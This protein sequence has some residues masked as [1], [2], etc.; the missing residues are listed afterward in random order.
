MPLTVPDPQ[1][2]PPT[3]RHLR[4]RARRSAV[5][6][7]LAASLLAGSGLTPAQA[8]PSAPAPLSVT[9]P[10]TTTS[11][12]STASTTL[13][14]EDQLARETLSPGDG[15]ASADGGTTGGTEAEEIV[16]VTSRAELVDAVAGDEPKIVRVTEDIHADE[17]DD[18]SLMTC[19]DYQRDGYSWE[20]YLEAFDPEQWDGAAEGP[21]EEAR[22]ASHR[23]QGEQIRL[24]PGSNT[25]LIGA[26]GATL[27]GF[28]V[29]LAEVDNVIVR[30]LR[31][32]DPYD[33]FPQW[34]GNEWDVEWDNVTLSGATHVWLDHMTLDGGETDHAA[35][36]EVFGQQVHRHDGML[37]I[38]RASDLVTVSWSRFDG[39]DKALLFG[40][41]DDRT[42]DRG[43]LRVTMH[44][45]EFTD[46]VQRAPRVRYGQVHVYNNL[47]RVAES[48]PYLYSWGVGVESSITA[49]NN[50]FEL[51]DG[52]T[53]ADIIHAW[54]GDGIV[55]EGTL[56]DG[57]PVNVLDAYLQKHPDAPLSD[58]IDGESGP[59]GVVQTAARAADAVDE[60]AG[61][62][63]TPEWTDPTDPVAAGEEVLDRIKAPDTTTEA[64]PVWSPTPTGFAA[65]PTDDLPQG[66]TGG[67]GGPTV[68]VEDAEELAHWAGQ[69][70]PVTIFIKGAVEVEELGEM[71]RVAGDKTIVGLNSR[72]ALVGGGF[73]LDEVQNV[74][75]RNLRIRDSYVPG[76]WDGK[77]ND[78]DGVRVDTSSHV[79]LDHI[80][81][82]RIGDGEADLRKDSTA[83]TLSWNIF[84]DHNKAIGVGWTDNV[85]TTLTMHHNWFSNSYQRNASIDNVA[86]GHLYNNLVE[87]FGQYGTMSRGA[88]QLVIEN[89]VY[90]H[91][92]DPV[93]AKD[94]ESQVELRGNSFTDVRG[95]RDDTGP[96]FE[97]SEHYDYTADPVDDV[98]RLVT[99]DAGPLG[100]P[101][102][103][104]RTVTVALDGS[105]DYES[106]TAAVGAAWRADR[107][108][109]IVIEPGVY[110]EVVR[111]WP[112]MEGITVRGATG[113]P[114]DVVISY[115]LAA[116]Q[117]KFYGGTFGLTGSPTVAVLAEDV[118]LQSLTIENA[119]D[120]EE[121]GPSQA[122]ALR[123][124]A[125]RVVLDDVR[126]LGNQDT[127]L[128]DTPS[129][130][131][132][133]RVY[134]RDSYLEGDVDFLFGGATAV[135]ENSHIHSLDRGEEHTNGYV[136]APAT[137]TGAPGFLIL[138]STFTSDAAEGTVHLGRP[139][140][141][142]SNPDVEP[143]MIVRDSE[144][145]AHIATPAWADMGGHSWEDSLLAEY[146]NTG[147]GAVP[148]GET[149]EGRPQL[150]EEE[151]AEHT[152][153]AYLTGDDTW[154]PWR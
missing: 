109:D 78:H 66:T 118:T 27:T 28:Q 25:T 69:E 50:A 29:E 87:G 57:E 90:A 5:S 47:Y 39:H 34:K 17:A 79:W 85:E 104:G 128:A 102:K 1:T 59:H 6:T 46:L 10:A 119:Y 38:V 89:S 82:T 48:A 72:A 75:I 148:D 22:R 23:A 145:G 12:T 55:E 51:G 45:N 37:D 7:L 74:I 67:T 138:D 77:E 31:I 127:F 92:E 43:T 146:G 139:W 20:D 126:L 2:R 124:A 64:G 61:A 16:E 112:G 97:P 144:L 106:V 86:A 151:A 62:T 117:E 100:A 52:V 35:Q 81:F 140:H 105:R 65:T 152:R 101:E 149:W 84:R 131:E 122:V 54:G 60:H 98:R 36:P 4:R 99:A 103:V 110:E 30:N 115:D 143:S 94:P 40:N 121:H 56:V 32:S 3:S 142:S 150:T 13:S 68:T 120:E 116:G 63:L 80:D 73:F 41:G 130:D 136:G 14:A 18:G 8:T 83:M 111:L 88:A 153:E 44:H 107:P 137:H 21:L 9:P 108:V 123:T 33:C 11:T 42:S 113:D 125:D 53:A 133:A 76:D 114:E 58:E 95:R 26:E 70:E 134:M 147:P 154:R 49:R 141:P 71:I 129:R 24:K 132:G 15:W 135:V 93:V 91:G 19:E 96:T